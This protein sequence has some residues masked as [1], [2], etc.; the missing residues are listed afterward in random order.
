MDDA[1]AELIV[2]WYEELEARLAE[3]LKITRYNAQTKGLFLPPLANIV[4]DACSLVDTVLRE[5]YQG[6]KDRGELSIFDYCSYFEPLLGLSQVKTV[7][8]HYPLRY[9]RPF[10]GWYDPGTKQYISTAWWKSHNDLKHDRIRQ[11]GKATL[12][13]AVNS[14]CA[15]HQVMSKLS[16][17]AQALLRH[18]FLHFGKWAQEYAMSAVFG[19]TVNRDVTILVETE[20]F[21]TPVGVKAFPK[22]IEDIK[23]H[24]MVRGKRFWRYLGRE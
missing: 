5:E 17:F 2:N 15:L 18:E 6:L 3:L 12:E 1:A 23:L 16:V 10:E 4:V 21:A 24:D 7:L 14:V 22:K 11:S 20:L 19:P 13:N 8:L 9:V